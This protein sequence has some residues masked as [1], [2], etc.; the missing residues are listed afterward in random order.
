MAE[1]KLVPQ[2]PTAAFIGASWLVLL[3]GMTCYLLGLYNAEMALSEKG[4]YFTLLLFGLFSVISIQK[5][6]R[7]R[8]EDIPVTNIYYGV[9]WLCVVVSVVLLAIGLYNSGML[10]SEKGFYGLAMV[11]SL[12]S[13][14]AVQKNVRDLAVFAEI[15]KQERPKPRVVPPAAPSGLTG[16]PIYGQSATRPENNTGSN[17][18]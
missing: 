15:E 2:K 11:L 10:L 9:A 3:I 14:I 4:Y 8:A 1:T 16:A 13:A 17:P 7:D 5:T 6:I 12:F 18:G